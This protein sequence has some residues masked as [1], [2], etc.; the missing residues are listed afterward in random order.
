MKFGRTAVMAASALAMAGMVAGCGAGGVGSSSSGTSSSTSSKTITIGTLYASSGQYATASMPEYQGLKFWVHQVNANGGVYVKA[1]GKKEK[2]TLKAYNDQSST[3]TATT[4]Y[5]QLI[6][7][8]KVNMLVGDFG[9]V[10]TS[11]AVPIAEE[12]KVV[13]WD[14]SGSG[15]T[16]FDQ[17]PTDRYIVL[18]S[19]QSSGLWPD[20]LSTYIVHK[21][22]KK[23]AIVYDANDF[24]GSQ[25]ATLVKNLKAAGITPVY[26]HPV[27]TT[28]STYSTI[29]A[30]MEALKPQM[31][32]ELGYNTN[33][34]AFLQ[35][36]QAVKGNTAKVFTI[37]PGQQMALF[38]KDVGNS[39]LNNTYTYL[40]PPLTAVHSVNYGMSLPQFESAFS[41]YSSTSVPN[42]NFEDIM[43]YNTGLILQK[44]LGTS[45]SLS[46]N[47][48][49]AAASALSGKIT[50]VE[51]TYKI[52]T[53]TGAQEGVPFP[54]GRFSLTNGK[55]GI[56]DYAYTI[57]GEL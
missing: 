45:K 18:T 44:V 9:S 22:L 37:F 8:N 1:T 24:T 21:K 53:T 33:D 32:I 43:G 11:V 5:T 49:R 52:D 23:V 19:I 36:M 25:N 42:I 26:D 50:T 57:K 13:L 16:F 6:T 46:Q 15:T 29:V 38:Q 48:M 34:V 31:M 14:Q 27:P 39:A 55:L 20:S 40:A 28:T 3:Q 12:H 51:G 41:K 35:A 56:T 4:L 10:L 54:V 47:A 17:K 7:Q 2:V 30:S